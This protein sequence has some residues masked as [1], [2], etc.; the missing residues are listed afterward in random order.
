MDPIKLNI[1]LTRFMHEKRGDL[2]DIDMD[3]P[4]GRNEIYEKIFKRYRGRVAQIS[5]HVMF[6]QKSA[7]KEAIR[8]EGYN[9]F[10][11]NE[12]ELEDI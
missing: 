5:N 10:I 4:Y 2:P 9:K 12:F 1:S 6:K 8:K 3:F 7:I 11:P